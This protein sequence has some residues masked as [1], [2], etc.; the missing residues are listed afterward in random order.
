MERKQTERLEHEIKTCSD[1]HA[2]I[3]RNQQE[4]LR[5]SAQEYLNRL[6]AAK[7]LTKK[8]IVKDCELDQ[9]YAYQILSGRKKGEREKLLCL[10]LAMRLTAYE[11]NTWLYL[12]GKSKLYPRDKR[13]A[14]VLF[15]LDHGRTVASVNE[16][17]YQAGEKLLN[18]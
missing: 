15:G 14:V 6:I 11:A 5:M 18:E 9:I 17:L 13:D 8:E 10:A 16:L 1:I 12:C 4:L 7:G 3:E 2:Y